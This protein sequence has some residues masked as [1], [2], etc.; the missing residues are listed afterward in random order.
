MEERVIELEKQ[1][2][3]LQNNL[4]E[5]MRIQVNLIK[6]IHMQAETIEKM[7]KNDELQALAIKKIAEVMGAL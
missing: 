7:S 5:L 3:S 1:V 4:G 2:E 6:T